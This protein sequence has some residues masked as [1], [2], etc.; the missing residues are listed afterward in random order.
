MSLIIAYFFLLDI[1]A[2]AYDSFIWCAKFI[3]RC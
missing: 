1:D 3:I 2:V